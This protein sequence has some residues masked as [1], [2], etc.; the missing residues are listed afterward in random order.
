MTESSPDE[1]VLPRPVDR[2][3]DD[4][5]AMARQPLAEV[6]DGA[7]GPASNS[8]TI[9]ANAIAEPNEVRRST[10]RAALQ[11]A[12]RD[13]HERMHRDPTL[14]RLAAGTIGRDEYRRLLARSYG[15]YVVAEPI[16]GLVG[17]L[18]DCLVRDLAELGMPAA[19]IEGLPRCAPPPIG[20][21]SADMIGARYV[22]LGA[23]LGGKVMARAIAGGAGRGP[24]LPVRFLT[25][26]SADVWSAFAA[27]LE[28]SLP[29][30]V[31][32]ARAAKAAVSMFAAYE[33]WMTA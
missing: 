3:A 29:D 32:Q 33:E 5:Y 2:L 7:F 30:D 24:A 15:F 28:A 25:G 4:A 23:S 8:A 1:Q 19:A 20:H 13:V 6:L 11:T 22:L 27:G 12:T 10:A 31:S 21:D 18:T 14:S 9:I 26:I 16:I 17:G